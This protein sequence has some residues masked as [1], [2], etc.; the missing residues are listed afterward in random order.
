LTSMRPLVFLP[1]PLTS[2]TGIDFGWTSVLL[3]H[4]HIEYFRASRRK[5]PECCLA[6][7]GYSVL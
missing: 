6:S 7:F 1:A 4:T 5:F 3:L 2:F